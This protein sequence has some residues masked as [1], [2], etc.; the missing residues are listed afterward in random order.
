MSKIQVN[1]IVNHFDNGAPDCP[2]G[3]TVT[4][5][6]TFSGSVSIGGTLTYEDVTNVESIGVA[7]FRDDVNIGVGGTVAFFDVSTGRIGIGTDSITGQV[8]IDTI[9]ANRGLTLNAPGNGTYITF[10]TNDTAFGD[11][12]SE[13]GILGFGTNDLL[14]LNARG[15]K[16]LAFRTNSS[17]RLRITS[18]GNIGIGL[19]NPSQRLNLNI[20]GDQTWL[21]IDKT[22][23]ADEAMIQ[24]VHSTTNRG[25][26]IR[27]A[28]ADSSWV[29]GIDGS[30]SFVFTS[31]EA[32]DATGGTERMRLLNSGFLQCNGDTGTYSAFTGYS[33]RADQND[34]MIYIENTNS[35]M[36]G[37]RGGIHIQYTGANPNDTG[38]RFV[39]FDTTGGKR[40][41]VR[42]N[43]GIENFTGNNANLSDEREK[44]NIEA[45]DSTWS[46]LKH[47]DLKKFHYNEDADTDDK[48]YGVI[49]Q[50]I[51]PH[52]PEVITDWVKQ[53]AADAVLDEDGNVVTEA[54][55]EIIRMGV[56]EQQM[57]W[58]AIKALQEAQTRIETLEAKVTALEG[59]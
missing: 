3:L 37:V 6:T 58:M 12:G 8:Q 50:Q 54:K 29:V 34:T 19:T 10:E 52:C 35:T 38:A 9:S 53:D 25:S 23:A 47:W 44:K 16:D 59:A 22:R 7:T 43:G 26:K 2:K 33:L 4:G 57:M 56:K 21:Q 36:D 24:L 42:S 28:N 39:Q 40:F 17:E 30:E 27:Y 49:A 14:V 32:A 46:C 20:G 5:F 31:G 15:A 11:I 18:T 45:L 51:A 13:A 48:R 1:E 55:E 41:G